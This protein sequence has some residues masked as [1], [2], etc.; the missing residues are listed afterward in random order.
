MLF[1]DQIELK[2]KELNFFSRF[3]IAQVLLFLFKITN[4]NYV[5]LF[6]KN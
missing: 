2:V 3:D 5:V 1:T 6:L 4:R